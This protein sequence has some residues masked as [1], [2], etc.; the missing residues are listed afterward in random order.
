MDDDQADT[1][2]LGVRRLP[3]RAIMAHAVPHFA[4]SEQRQ[5]RRWTRQAARHADPVRARW[6]LRARCI[7]LD[8]RE[9]SQIPA[10]ASS[11]AQGFAG[12]LLLCYKRGM[13][14]SIEEDWIFR[15]WSRKKEK[16]RRIESSSRRA[17]FSHIVKLLRL[18]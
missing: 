14:S 1:S 2:P 15:F 18:S 17:S 16:G 9:V 3:R 12:K 4:C 5:V 11:G 8:Q 13:Q 6:H 10:G 7:P